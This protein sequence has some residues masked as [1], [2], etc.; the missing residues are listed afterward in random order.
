M[1]TLMS[2]SFERSRRRFLKHS[3]I[4][5]SGLLSGLPAILRAQQGPA[6]IAADSAR[7]MARYGLRIGDALADRAIVWSRADKEAR[8]FVEWSTHESFA[9]AIQVRGPHAI[10]ASDF[11]ARVD[12]TDL[13]SDAEVFVR[14]LFENLDSG[15]GRSEPVVGRFRTAPRKRRDL[16]FL[17]S[18]DTAGQGWGINLDFGGMKIYETMRRAEPDFFIHNGDTIYADGPLADEVKLADGTIWRNAFLDDVPAKR[19]VAETLD[20]FRGN[21]LY[22]LFD[23]NMRRFSAEVPQIW[24][25]DDHEEHHEWC[26]HLI[27]LLEDRHY[28]RVAPGWW[29]LYRRGHGLS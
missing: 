29:K 20:E 11:T 6:I 12:L 24:Q 18:G 3:A 9:N 5:G 15:K 8:M 1:E 2:D 16:R 25:W 14:V 28:R 23:D 22:N 10:A 19:K 13:P 17:W 21:H 4:A 27:A 7:P 26:I